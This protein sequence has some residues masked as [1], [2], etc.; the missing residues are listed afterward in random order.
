MIF[1]WEG[2]AFPAPVMHPFG[3]ITIEE[4]PMVRLR[5][6][7]L[8]V[9]AGLGLVC[10]CLSM[11]RIPL[12]DRLRCHSEADCCDTGAIPDSAVPIAEGPV[13]NGVPPNGPGITPIP[14]VAPQNG[15]PPL[16]SPPRI[17]PQPQALPIPYTP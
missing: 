3:T 11:S 8:A 10:G 15:I 1:V 6:A 9:A 2:P 13:I 14:S 16:A 5:L 12:L 17:A 7:T 4:I